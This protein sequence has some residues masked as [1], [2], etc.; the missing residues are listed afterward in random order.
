MLGDQLLITKMGNL[1]DQIIVSEDL[2]D[3]EKKLKYVSG[4]AAIHN[5]EII[6]VGGDG[7]SKDMP[8]RA[9]YRGEFQDNGYS[10]HF[11]VFVRVRTK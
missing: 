6:Q 7:R 1:F 3:E 4:S 8:R 11:P 9:I 2:M 10:D 5:P